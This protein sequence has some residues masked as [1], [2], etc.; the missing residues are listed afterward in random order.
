M[1][2]EVE[3]VLDHFCSDEVLRTDLAATL[4]RPGFALHGTSACRGGLL[5]LAAYG[6]VAGAVDQRAYR[7]AA[8]TELMMAASCLFDHI[9]DGDTR[10]GATSIAVETTRAIGVLTCANTAA[11]EGLAG[12]GSPGGV[13]A[14]RSMQT[15]LLESCG[16][17]LS[18]VRASL[19][20]PASLDEALDITV[21]KAGALGE[22]VAAAGAEAAGADR[23]VT[24][25]IGDFGRD[26]FTYLQLI[27]D[28]R[29]IEEDA[30]C[31]LN[32]AAAH[33]DYKGT[34]P[35]LF[36]RNAAARRGGSAATGSVSLMDRP[37]GADIRSATL[38]V[39]VVAEAHLDQ[40]RRSLQR[41]EQRSMRVQ[42]LAAVLDQ[43]E[44]AGT[45][46]LGQL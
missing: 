7:I 36:L 13:I 33:Q 27:D 38:F 12:T 23:V 39:S 10:D 43:A 1:R 42:E 45:F 30:G 3:A 15:R 19:D 25:F 20:S 4:R 26:L 46:V 29:D 9:A 8:A 14:L 22:L 6:C 44:D 34:V 28:A 35:V 41:L 37:T 17:Q 32:G 24:G 5:T 11:V 16:G 18:D 31:L 2:H 21:R 40:A